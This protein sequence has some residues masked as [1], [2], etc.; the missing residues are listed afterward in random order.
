MENMPLSESIH[1][2]KS[3][4]YVQLP[5]NNLLYK[6]LGECLQKLFEVSSYFAEDNCNNKSIY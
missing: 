1:L 3:L 6:C 4:L 5:L 2:K